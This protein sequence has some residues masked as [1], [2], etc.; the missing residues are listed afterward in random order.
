MA[1]ISWTFVKFVSSPVPL[2]RLGQGR[3]YLDA[4]RTDAESAGSS[5]LTVLLREQRHLQQAVVVIGFQVKR[6]AIVIDG[7]R[8]TIS[9]EHQPQ[10]V[11]GLGGCAAFAQV[12]FT[13]RGGL[14]HPSGIR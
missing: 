8:M 1:S 12:R 13:N 4:L 3:R 6:L 11:I 2:R 14:F 7:P 10:Q 5:R 9:V